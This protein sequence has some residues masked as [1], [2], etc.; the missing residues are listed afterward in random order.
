MSQILE[1]RTFDARRYDIV[2]TGLLAEGE[3]IASVV[4][5]TADQGALTFGAG[6]V[7]T[8]PVSYMNGTT[9][10]ASTVIQVE[11]SAGAIP[12]G[13]DSMNLGVPNLLCTVRAR[14]TTSQSPNQVEA[15]LLLL[16]RDQPS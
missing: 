12:K 1:K 5:I 4:S 14:F 2:C 9:A 16:L 3:T 10:I 6:V 8:V 7:N 11:I 15:T 13:A